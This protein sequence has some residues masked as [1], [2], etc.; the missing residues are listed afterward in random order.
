MGG[1]RNESN[2]VPVMA[3][4]IN[5]CMTVFDW[6]KV[7][8]TYLRLVPSTRHSRTIDCIILNTALQQRICS[9]ALVVYQSYPHRV[10]VQRCRRALPSVWWRHC[11]R[12]RRYPI[13][14]DSKYW[15]VVLERFSH[16]SSKKSSPHSG[17]TCR[18][19]GFRRPTD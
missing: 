19:L 1:E 15:A 10:S 4:E 12:A 11:A 7:S 5:A 3:Q 14:P 9:H 17:L 13:E 2:R 18:S 8:A 16:L 6:C